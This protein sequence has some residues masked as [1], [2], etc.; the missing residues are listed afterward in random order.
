MRSQKTQDP[1]LTEGD[2][3]IPAALGYVDDKYFGSSGKFV[4]HI[5]DAHCN[6]D[7][8]K[9]IY[10][11]IDWIVKKYGVEV[12]NLEGG[13]GEY[14]LS[15][16]E[17]IGERPIKDALS[18]L[19]LK[20]GNLNGAELYRVYNPS[21]V[22]LAGIED[23]G[24]Y[25]ENLLAYQS[26]LAYRSQV[27]GFLSKASAALS[28]LAEKTFSEEIRMFD[29]MGELF[30]SNK[31]ELGKYIAYLY[32]AA[33]AHSV[34][35][36]EFTDL[37][38][39]SRLLVKEKEI[40]FEAAGKERKD[41]VALLMER[42]SRIERGQFA[43]RAGLFEQGHI[44]EADFYGYLLE[45]A[46]EVGIE[47]DAFPNIAKY[48]DYLSIYG[49]L[50]ESRLF[51]QIEKLEER[52]SGALCRD[53]EEKEL[54]GYISQTR[55][56]KK[57]FT[58]EL[59][60]GQYD[61][62]R[63]FVNISGL[64]SFLRPRI[65]ENDLTTLSEGAPYAAHAFA[66]M[67]A[68]YALAASRDGVFL[69]NIEENMANAGV[70]ASIVVTGGFHSDNL[71]RILKEKGISYV[72]VSPSFVNDRSY[73]S[74][75]MDILCGRKNTVAADVGAIPASTIQVR[76]LWSKLGVDTDFVLALAN[77]LNVAIHTEKLRGTQ[78]IIIQLGKKRAFLPRDTG[79]DVCDI[80]PV[81]YMSRQGFAVIDIPK[82]MGL[83]PEECISKIKG[84]SAPGARSSAVNYFSG[85][86]S[87]SNIIRI[88]ISE[89]HAGNG[90]DGD[91]RIS[92][93]K[94]YLRMYDGEII[95]QPV[96]GMRNIDI[97]DYVLD[98]RSGVLV[99][100][101]SSSRSVS[102]YMREPSIV[103]GN[104]EKSYLCEKLRQ[105]FRPGITIEE[106]KKKLQELLDEQHK[107]EEEGRCG[108]TWLID[109]GPD[110]EVYLDEAM[111]K[112]VRGLHIFDRT[113]LPEGIEPQNLD[114]DAG[115]Y[116]SREFVQEMQFNISV[117]PGSE[118]VDIQLMDTWA[119]EAKVR[120]YAEAAHTDHLT[121]LSNRR[122]F[123]KVKG[124]IAEASRVTV[125]F[126][127]ID[128]FKHFNDDY[129]HDVG[130]RVLIAV[131]HS[132]LKGIRGVD[133][134]FRWGGDEFVVVLPD[135]M[136]SSGQAV[137][138]N[139]L[140]NAKKLQI[141]G[142]NEDDG[143]SVTVGVV[144]SE[145]L[146]RGED[147]AAFIE[148]AD[149]MMLEAKQV[150]KGTVFVFDPARL[151]GS[152]VDLFEP[153]RGFKEVPVDVLLGDIKDVMHV[154]Y[155][156]VLE[157]LGAFVDQELISGKTQGEA[158]RGVRRDLASARFSSKM[159]LLGKYEMTLLAP[160][161]G[162][163]AKNEAAAKARNDLRVLCKRF[164]RLRRSIEYIVGEKPATEN[165]TEAQIA[166][167]KIY[168]L[169]C[170]Y[171]SEEEKQDGEEASPLEASPFGTVDGRSL[172]WIDESGRIMQNPAIGN[173]SL[174]L[175]MWNYSH[176]MAHKLL[177]DLYGETNSAEAIEIA[178]MYIP[179][180]EV[181]DAAKDH[182]IRAL[183]KAMSPA[184]EAIYPD[185]PYDIF[186]N[187][188]FEYL[189]VTRP[190]FFELRD[191]ESITKEAFDIIEREDLRRATESYLSESG[192]GAALSSLRIEAI[193][194]LAHVLS[195]RSDLARRE[196]ITVLSDI[197]KEGRLRAGRLRVRVLSALARAAHDRP[198]LFTRSFSGMDL[199][200]Q[201]EI[202]AQAM[203]IDEFL[204]G[205]MEEG[206]KKAI[207]ALCAYRMRQSLFKEEQ[208][209]PKW[210]D[211]S[212]D[213][214]I[215]G[216]DMAIMKS[217][218]SSVSV[219]MFF[220]RAGVRENCRNMLRQMYVD[221]MVR[222][223]GVYREMGAP[224]LRGE[225]VLKVKENKVHDFVTPAEGD[226]LKF[227]L[228]VEKDMQNDAGRYRLPPCSYDVTQSILVYFLQKAEYPASE[229]DI[230]IF[231][232]F[233]GER[234]PDEGKYIQLANIIIHPLAYE[235]E[236]WETDNPVFG[237]PPLFYATKGD[238]GETMFLSDAVYS[239]AD[240]GDM[241]YEGATGGFMFAQ[242]SKQL[243][244]VALKARMVPEEKRTKREKALALV[245]DN[246]AASF[247]KILD[248]D[249][250][251]P[252]LLDVAWVSDSP[253]DG[254][255]V[256]KYGWSYGS[257]ARR[258]TIKEGFQRL[259]EARKS[260]KT[261][262]G[263]TG[264][265]YSLLKDCIGAVNIMISVEEHRIAEAEAR[266]PILR[267][268][269]AKIFI[270]PVDDLSAV[271]KEGQDPFEAILEKVKAAFTADIAD[272]YR[273]PGLADDTFT[274]LVEAFPESFLLN[275]KGMIADTVTTLALQAARFHAETHVVMYPVYD[276]AAFAKEIEI[277]S[278]IRRRLL[279]PDYGFRLCPMPYLAGSDDSRA[280]VLERLEGMLASNPGCRAMIYADDMIFD[281]NNDK[282]KE[283]YGGRVIFVR[284]HG[285][286]M[287]HA[288][289]HVDFQLR[290]ALAVSVMDYFD[291]RNNL[292]SEQKDIL[293]DM[294]A[295]MLQLITSDK[296]L[297][298]AFRANPED[299]VKGLLVIKPAERISWDEVDERA[300]A[301][302]QFMHSL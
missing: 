193:G 229:D 144:G 212:I 221:P 132:I 61:A 43:F 127:D 88:I 58:L 249:G 151:R 277:T 232:Q 65:P 116:G 165:V 204:P 284:E 53:S 35:M 181:Q 217:R 298:S 189:R 112:G 237:M 135:M 32:R 27:E 66:G 220:A 272:G 301:S 38:E 117:P 87:M 81:D 123:E 85:N 70:S 275:E 76:S 12:V 206:D 287:I 28:K 201:M 208:A 111:G 213:A 278:E 177:A 138:Q 139:I 77:R 63:R 198:E 241:A 40:D 95:E 130:D 128:E 137:A 25:E 196:T 265:T 94:A 8:Q 246:F 289:S 179:F 266:E 158:L 161:S 39:M 16:L 107:Y 166:I 261:G 4:F 276:E 9:A 59:S 49:Q 83:P 225:I 207:R 170:K 219:E 280:R 274:A 293:K 126:I 141:Q 192:K 171:L 252:Y 164:D 18:E 168:Y 292:K 290:A 268:I 42:L 1:A 149:K 224:Y 299:L 214:D 5:K 205:R 250:L 200:V 78:G 122:Y 3:V 183:L 24:L 146:P 23:P 98:V 17:E 174:E 234:I 84:L 188:A 159:D 48:S 182:N 56:L 222:R 281:G 197:L 203:K 22:R 33:S 154:L 20:E 195:R 14:D 242:R 93:K 302:R 184:L 153:R 175:K 114:A 251:S 136:L 238:V 160:A 113:K 190:G 47:K 178:A 300:Q 271:V 15:V 108:W 68:F 125:L 248:E 255:P 62:A 176:E 97:F 55:L 119:A 295:A 194:T 105:V 110:G 13:S 218:L 156:Q 7:A 258:E 216:E 64:L 186:V 92:P 131:A 279:E 91:V 231:V 103:K 118:R 71:C 36:E 147:I 19:Y 211:E 286:A 72:S 262:K 69:E 148:K 296:D 294:I 52:I 226:E 202:L 247:R 235:W 180:K 239:K 223:I 145:T 187:G 129:S 297:A 285:T 75:Y 46:R 57:M 173:V 37:L 79:Y 30:D 54:L 167:D 157:K 2:I 44:A 227:L 80:V 273:K 230:N 253:M 264:K 240:E 142:L 106:K 162:E 143:V 282:M 291:E 50:D 99:C 100:E 254:V 74:P 134:A 26:V 67:I 104:N 256:N 215:P 133:Y 102:G 115:K 263:L 124:R 96:T 11:L 31:M 101:F 21:S 169:L 288:F 60:S 260:D 90:L 140:S 199:S 29:A 257:A 244:T 89:V 269:A 163:Q 152:E 10:A 270:P 228:G 121:G 243:L 267:K 6:Y 51:G 45:K 86:E 172:M 150:N 109:R 191:R 210:V 155:P 73:T 209:F 245:W 185:M 34:A 120:T 41:L 233:M 283:K 82:L 236:N 259:E